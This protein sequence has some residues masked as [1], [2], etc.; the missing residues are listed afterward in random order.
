MLLIKTKLRPSNIHGLGLFADE[1]ICSGQDV[2]RF[3]DGLDMILP[4]EIFESFPPLAKAFVCRYGTDES[5][6]GYFI[7]YGD[8]ARFINHS[9]YPNLIWDETRQVMIASRNIYAGEEITENYYDNESTSID[10]L[11]D[12]YVWD[13]SE[14]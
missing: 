7:L 13:K 14:I 2:W 3:Q 1:N 8:D 6:E 5:A 9:R 11:D 12:R 10:I 4:L